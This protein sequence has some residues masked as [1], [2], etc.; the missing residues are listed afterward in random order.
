MLHLLCGDDEHHIKRFAGG[1]FFDRLGAFGNQAFHGL[2]LLA[3]RC[4]A[5][6]FERTL[7]PKAMFFGLFEMLLKSSSEALVGGRLGHLG[8]GLGQLR[9]GAVEI[10][11]FV[12]E[13][14]FKRFGFHNTEE[15][16]TEAAPVVKIFLERLLLPRVLPVKRAAFGNRTAADMAV[17]AIRRLVWPFADDD[18][19]VRNRLARAFI[20]R[21]LSEAGVRVDV[22]KAVRVANIPLAQLRAIAHDCD[23]FA[24][25]GMDAVGREVDDGLPLDARADAAE[26]ERFCGIELERRNPAVFNRDLPPTEDALILAVL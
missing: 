24:W 1:V 21:D 8:K 10:L 22:L 19:F 26:D 14:I 12:D 7:E 11:E 25:L 23:V 4:A 2:A 18:I 6:L 15:S 20:E 17:L 5:E 9:F 16:E 3:A 13:D